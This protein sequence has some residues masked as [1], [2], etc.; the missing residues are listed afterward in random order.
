[1]VW[2]SES[3]VGGFI[4]ESDSLAFVCT[5][6]WRAD[7]AGRNVGV[8][9]SATQ[10]GHPGIVVSDIASSAGPRHRDDCGEIR[11]LLGALR[12]HHTV[13]GDVSAGD[14]SGPAGD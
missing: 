2:N 6:S 7:L 9:R 1:M 10:T 11:H 14:W 3:T 13:A 12:H 4:Y 8:R 5:F